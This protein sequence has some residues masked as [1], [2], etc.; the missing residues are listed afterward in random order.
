MK[1]DAGKS[2]KEQRL[3]LIITI[4]RFFAIISTEITCIFLKKLTVDAAA[5]LTTFFIVV[6][7]VIQACLL[8]GSRRIPHVLL[9]VLQSGLLSATA[10]YCMNRPRMDLLVCLGIT[11]F[12]AAFLLLFFPLLYRKKTISGIIGRD[13]NDTH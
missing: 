9:F 1:T 2:K 6:E 4:L 10:L 13:R 12:V 3:N 11:A 8:K 5:R 7:L